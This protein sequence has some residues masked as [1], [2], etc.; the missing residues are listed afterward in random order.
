MVSSALAGYI[1]HLPD[2]SLLKYLEQFNSS[3]T[4]QLSEQIDPDGNKLTFHYTDNMLTSIT[5]ADGNQT[6]LYYDD[7]TSPWYVT[8]VGTPDGREVQFSH[9][10]DYGGLTNIVDAAGISSSIAYDGNGWPTNLTTP[11]G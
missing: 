3:T 10:L 8:R 1:V 6:T 11:Y 9:D 2:G 7:G 5:D 4:F